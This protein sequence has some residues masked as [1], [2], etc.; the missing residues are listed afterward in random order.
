MR[1]SEVWR[2][3][4]VPGALAGL[5]G[6]LLLGAAMSEMGLLPDIAQIVRADAAV[7]GFIVLMVLAAGL[8]AGFGVLVWYQRPGAGE[9]LFW[10]LVYGSFCWYLGPLTLLPLLRGEGLT[11][12]VD[13]AQ[14]AF[15]VYLGLVLYG[16]ATGL[17]LVF[18][19]WLWRRPAGTLHFSGGALLRGVLAGLLA[20]GLLGAALNAQDQLLA[21]VAMS[22][23]GSHL[24]AWLITLVIG[25][26]A[27]GVFSLLYSRPTD[28][29]GAGLIRGSVYG[30]FWWVAGALTLVPLFGGVGL[31]WSLNEV[32]ASFATL[33][34][35]L[36]FGAAIALFY[37]WLGA[38]VRL[39]FSDYVVGGDEEGVGTQGLRII[40]RSVLAGL[41]GGLLFSLVM[42]QNGFLPNVASLI[43]LASTVAG[44]F[45]HLGIGVII[46]TSYGLLF[47]RQSYDVGSAL[48]WGVSYGFFWSIL[49]PLTLMPIF[50]GIAPQ[51]TVGAVATTF[52]NLIGHLAY[53]AGLGVT[54]YLL[55]ARYSPWW[56]PR[57]QAEVARVAHQKEQVLTSAPALWTL[58]I[59][60]G[61]TLSIL[62]GVDPIDGNLIDS[63]YPPGRVGR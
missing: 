22:S 50:L 5:V 33:P 44:F 46:G 51:W 27:G 31:T 13:S 4:L 37:Q 29:A 62:L 57:R 2:T 25:L 10:G 48:G 53:G 26:L 61:L 18:L 55:E 24:A 6:G 60:T 21:S 17:V 45:V 23:G 52:P 28:G 20:A 59:A 41:V 40:G 54:F 16:G 30:F 63:V 3:A 38:L 1:W 32:Q 36:L 14:A 35:Y 11:W 58:L 19:R 15:P 47:H 7:V 56:I 9:T 42:L 39:L 8:G 49:G 34:G 43:G 12:D